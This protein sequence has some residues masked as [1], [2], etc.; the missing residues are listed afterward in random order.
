MAAPKGNKY[1]QFRD[2][3]GR[4][5]KYQP[6]EL[7]QEAVKY[8]EWIEENPLWESVIIQR[9]IKTIED[10]IEKTV[11]S[12]KMPKMRAMTITGFCLFADIALQTFEEYKKNIDF[13]DI[14]TRIE[15]IIRDQKFT[16]AAAEL[17]NPNII[18]REIGLKEQTEHSGEIKGQSINLFY[19]GKEINLKD[20]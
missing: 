16:G 11:Y 8:F 3:H 9:G 12:T 6:E 10:G 18:A 20:E 4:D 2:K 17:L 14:V 13:T 1:W 15:H 19:N 5:Y 7:W